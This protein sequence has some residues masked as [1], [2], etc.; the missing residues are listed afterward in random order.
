MQNS[1]VAP[2]GWTRRTR[3]S[4]SS[5]N[6]TLPSAP[7]AAPRIGVELGIAKAT[8]PPVIGLGLA[9][10]V[11]LRQADAV[12]EAPDVIDADAE[13]VG[14]LLGDPQAHE[15]IAT[16]AANAPITGHRDIPVRMGGLTLTGAS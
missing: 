13:L 5:V 2:L 10:M 11:R 6:H 1:V 4:A 16:V 3:S 15:R 14:T 9:P 12:D 8:A 7:S